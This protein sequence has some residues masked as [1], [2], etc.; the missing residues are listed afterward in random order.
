M[1]KKPLAP[2]FHK[3]VDLVESTVPI[4]AT[5][6]ASGCFDPLHAGHIEFLGAAKRAGDFLVVAVY[7][8]ESTAKL[9]GAGRPVLSVDDRSQLAASIDA[10]DAVLIVTDT[11]LSDVLPTLR[12][13]VCATG[14]A[15][16]RRSQG[17]QEVMRTL[18]VKE[19]VVGGARHRSSTEIV[20]RIKEA[21]RGEAGDS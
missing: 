8:D 16:K 11:D 10:V 3:A 19:V 7:D 9:K 14:A 15:D 5:V 21:A 12:P 6:L 13:D 1:T 20:R 17:E 18:G 4:G 2:I